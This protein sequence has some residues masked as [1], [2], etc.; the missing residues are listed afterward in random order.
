MSNFESEDTVFDISEH[1]FAIL[2]SLYGCFRR[3]AFRI[4]FEH[5][6]DLDNLRQ[7]LDDTIAAINTGVKK[8]R[9]GTVVGKIPEG[10]AYLESSELQAALDEVVELLSDAKLLYSRAWA[11]GYFFDLSTIGR[12]GIAFDRDHQDEATRVAVMIDEARNRALEIVNRIYRQIGMREFPYI[13]TWERYQEGIDLSS[14]KEAMPK[15]K[16]RFLS[17][18][19]ILELKPNFFGLGINLNELNRRLQRKL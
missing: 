3:P 4:K 2:K 15:R 10:E 9:D 17:I 16:F 7:A 8:T 14:I 11:A 6:E 12:R 19:D 13:A 1:D 5:E 18:L